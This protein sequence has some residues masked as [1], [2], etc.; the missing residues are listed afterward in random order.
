MFNINQSAAKKWTEVLRP[1]AP[2]V[3]FIIPT[4][5]PFDELTADE[6]E[7]HIQMELAKKKEQHPTSG[8]QSATP[9]TPINGTLASESQK[10]AEKETAGEMMTPQPTAPAT[11]SATIAA[12]DTPTDSVVS[13]PTQEAE[14]SKPPAKRLKLD[15]SDNAEAQHETQQPPAV[16]NNDTAASSASPAT[17]S[18]T[19]TVQSQTQSTQQEPM[20]EEEAII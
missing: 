18:E 12:V 17:T 4:W 3:K 14:T 8:Q 1:P 9:A 20:Q 5:V 19:T 10:L 7:A 2:G 11:E 13:L 16:A 6:H 15:T